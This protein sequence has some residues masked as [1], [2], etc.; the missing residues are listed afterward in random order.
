MTLNK[1]ENNNFS[2][3]FHIF[4]ILMQ[5]LIAFIFLTLFFFNYVVV[6][7]KHE[8]KKQ[9]EFIVD[10]VYQDVNKIYNDITKDIPNLPVDILPII[11]TLIDSNKTEEVINEDILNSNNKIKNKSYNIIFISIIVMLSLYIIFVLT[12]KCIPPVVKHF[13]NGVIIV[14]F[15]GI[16]ELCFLTFFSANYISADPNKVR[17]HI[18]EALHEYINS[19]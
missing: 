19:R 18:G 14:I 12:K 9:V 13:S 4:A 16:V 3:I 2:N 8:F 11:N 15:I 6:V 7:E 10:N 17:K 5:V 1:C